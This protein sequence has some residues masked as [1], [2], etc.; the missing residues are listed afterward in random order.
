MSALD[1]P[2]LGGEVGVALVELASEAGEPLRHV[3]M[4]SLLDAAAAMEN[5]IHCHGRA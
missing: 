5:D 4:R 2:W 3:V 1:G